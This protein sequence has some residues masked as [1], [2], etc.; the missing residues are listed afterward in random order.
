[1]NGGFLSG[2]ADQ[3]PPLLGGLRISLLLTLASLA[4]GLPL[5]L[6]FALLVSSRNRAL[7]LPA[8]GLVEL[9]RGTPAL[10]ML[11]LVYFGLPKIEVSL[12]SFAAATVSLAFIA[13]AYMSEIVRAGLNAVPAGQREAAR[14]SGLTPLDEFRFIVLPQ[15]LRIALAPLLNFAIVL[16]QVTSLAFAI[17]VPEMLS[18]AYAAGSATFRHLEVL[19]LAGLLYAA[20]VVPA[21]VGVRALERRLSRSYL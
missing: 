5:A 8:L 15:G 10:V 18:K 20:I 13:G 19:T 6:A 4:I 17:A 16:F 21:A 1:M 3:L 14:A 2:W 12:E 11:Q 9:G 7:R